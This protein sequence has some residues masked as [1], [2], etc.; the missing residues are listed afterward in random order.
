M[1]VEK[2]Y[3]DHKMSMFQQLTQLRRKTKQKQSA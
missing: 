1:F 3:S 2:N